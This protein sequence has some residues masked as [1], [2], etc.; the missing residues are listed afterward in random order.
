MGASRW[1]GI[2]SPLV[3]TPLVPPGLYGHGD[4]LSSTLV[5][6]AAQTLSEM[7]KGADCLRGAEG[8]DGRS[9]AALAEISLAV[10]M[11]GSC[12]AEITPESASR[13]IHLATDYRGDTSTTVPLDV[14]KLS[15]PSA[16]TKPQAL[17]F[18]LGA[19]GREEVERFFTEH[20]MPFVEGSQALAEIG[21]TAYSDPRLR[22]T[23]R[24]YRRFFIGC[25]VLA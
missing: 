7:E 18:L 11:M 25:E 17:E 19:C 15:L 20:V 10:S 24:A 6:N 14:D 12:P 21:V 22:C 13:D 9:T 4:L 8:C 1:R 2:Y 23:G 5:A 3:A 16:G